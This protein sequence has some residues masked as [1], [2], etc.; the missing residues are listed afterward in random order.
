MNVTFSFQNIIKEIKR[1]QLRDLLKSINKT[2]YGR[3]NELKDR[4]ICAIRALSLQAQQE[5][6]GS[7][8]ATGCVCFNHV[9]KPI[10]R[11]LI[12]SGSRHR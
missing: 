3:I 7:Y 2:Y 5:L 1:D 10:P 6:L 4:A 11:Q 12:C 9:V 8:M